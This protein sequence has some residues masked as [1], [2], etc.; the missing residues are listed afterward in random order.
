[1]KGRYYADGCKQ[2]L[3]KTKEDIISPT[4]IIETVLLTSVIDAIE[5]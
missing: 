3:W 5:G 4:Y 1:M 2:H